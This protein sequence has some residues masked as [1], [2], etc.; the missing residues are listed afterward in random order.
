MLKHSAN[1]TEARRRFLRQGFAGA[2]ALGLGSGAMAY[3][4]SAA[5]ATS[6]ATT[7]ER[8]RLIQEAHFGPKQPATGREG[9]AI[10]SHPLATR[11]AVETMRSGGNACDAALC[12]SITQTVVEPHMTGITGILSLLY[13]DA[14]TGQTHYLNGNMNAPLA[15]LP[16]FSVADIATGRGVGVPGFWGAF[17]AAH[18]RFGTRPR[19]ELMQPAIGFARDGFETHPFLWGEIFVQAHR[20]GLTE[21]GRE[22]FLP[23]GAIPRPGE[24]LYQ[25]RAA[26]TLE[27]LAEEGNDYFYRGDFATAYSDVVGKA[28]GVVTREDFEAYAVR[29]MEP[30][31]STYRGH[32]VVGSPPPDNGGTHI[33]EMLNMIELLDL[34]KLGPPNESGETLFQLSRIHNAVY[35]EGAKQ[36]D[37]ETHPMPLETIVSKEY[38]KMRFDLLQMGTPISPDAPPPPGSNHVTVVDGAGNV[39]S[40][41]HSCMSFPWSNGLFAGGVTVCASGAHFLRVMPKPGHRATTYVAPNIIF[42]SGK[43]VLTS[44]SPSVGLL[45][46]IV[47]NTTNLLDFGIPIEES[48]LR[49]RFGGG[50]FTVP[51]ASMVEVDVPE[52]VRADAEKRGLRFE[53]VNPWNWHHGA[54]EGIHID[55]DTLRACGDPRR[56]SKAE[57]V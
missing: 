12:A 23:T 3:G 49:S 6:A 25:R 55:G 53:V 28:G 54:F 52:A 51:G 5:P 20:I 16:G 36:N 42:K 46:N 21:A 43:P 40:I 4:E 41:I 26:D 56:C 9:M 31:R 30:A 32:D 27:R 17:Q 48:V 14:A 33:I 29:W 38:A 22:I 1:E 45:A 37:P 44:G 47:Q 13:Y 18:E 10:T 50:S 19:R 8:Q 39:A 7:N 35:I 15:A 2:G 57:A 24:M 34:Q 11:A